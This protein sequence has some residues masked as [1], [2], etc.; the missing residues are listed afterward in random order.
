MVLGGTMSELRPIRY[1]CVSAAYEFFG[2]PWAPPEGRPSLTGV[3]EL[4][5]I[6]VRRILRL[7]SMFTRYFPFRGSAVSAI[8][9]A[10][11]IREGMIPITV[12]FPPLPG[13]CCFRLRLLGTLENE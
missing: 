9:K 3:L 11:T 12:T 1:E 6:L 10:L 8:T 4:N 5:T 7:R 13:L 2:Q